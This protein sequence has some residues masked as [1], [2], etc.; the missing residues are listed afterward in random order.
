MKYSGLVRIT[1]VEHVRDYVL[2]LEFTDGTVGEV[3][4]EDS[5][6]GP[7]F[8]RHRNDPE[9][10][11]QVYLDEISGTIA[12]PNETDLDPD[13]LYALV[14]GTYDELMRGDAASG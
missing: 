5:I 4:L 1:G 14:T 7:V 11:R 9:F 3:D 12:W 6:W 2:R 10:F 13:V 8:E